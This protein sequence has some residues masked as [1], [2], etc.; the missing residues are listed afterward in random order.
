MIVVGQVVVSSDVGVISSWNGISGFHGVGRDEAPLRSTFPSLDFVK[1]AS[2]LMLAVSDSPSN[3]CGD[4]FNALGIRNAALP[5]E[6]RL[7]ITK[8]RFR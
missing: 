4:G 7:E 5:L 8:I 1:I 6:T 2:V 3:A